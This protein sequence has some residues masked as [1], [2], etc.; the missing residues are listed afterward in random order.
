M[1][2]KIK[3]SINL[4]SVVGA[5]YSVKAMGLNPVAAI[6]RS[7][8]FDFR[9]CLHFSLSYLCPSVSWSTK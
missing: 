6:T 2:R 7:L 8:N 4:D 3:D 1:V 5:T 9:D